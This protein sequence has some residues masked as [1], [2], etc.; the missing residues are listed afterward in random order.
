MKADRWRR[1]PDGSTALHN[2]RICATIR[3]SGRS[4]DQ[5]MGEPRL[6]ALLPAASAGRGGSSG[7]PVRGGIRPPPAPRLRGGAAPPGVL[8]R[9]ALATAFQ[10]LHGV[11]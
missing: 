8:T 10:R 9:R 1:V 4:A 11:S 6:G 3:Y 2:V 5:G 7:T